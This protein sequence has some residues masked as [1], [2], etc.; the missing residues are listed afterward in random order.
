MTARP[1]AGK[2]IVVTRARTQS[3]ALVGRLE[4]L[5]A[6][7]VELPVIVIGDAADGGVA[8]AAAADRLA[9][10]AYDWV[11]LTSP[12]AA[13]RLL[14][15]LEGRR[16]PGSVRWAA[17]GAGTARALGDA[18]VAAD[19]VPTVSLAESLADAFPAPRPGSPDPGRSGPGDHAP[20][21]RVPG[22]PDP[23]GAA[24][25]VLFPR[26]EK[27]RGGLAEGLRA[28]GWQVDEVIAYRTL[29]GDPGPEALDAAGRADAVAFTSSSTVERTAE[30]L[31]PGGLPPAVASIGPVTSSSVRSAGVDV[32][33]EADPHTLDGLVDALVATLGHAERPPTT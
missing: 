11:A 1:L 2:S 22:N 19:L 25:T 6:T 3:A 4:R 14:S 5:G 13:A 10:G 31:G 18:G 8:L 32:S 16:V 33:V 9:T 21:F 30:L 12:N 28:K 23:A 20:I 15:A 26:A 7:V 27:V 24:G 29:P 17:V